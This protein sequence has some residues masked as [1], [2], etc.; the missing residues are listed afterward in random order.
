MPRLPTQP[1]TRPGPSLLQ[2]SRPPPGVLHQS[3]APRQTS[4]PPPSVMSAIAGPRPISLQ[5]RNDQTNVMSVPLRLP[6]QPLPPPPALQQVVPTPVQTNKANNLDVLAHTLKLADL[7]FDFEPAEPV[8]GGGGSSLVPPSETQELKLE[9]LKHLRDSTVPKVVN[10]GDPISQLLDFSN[11]TYQDV[12]SAADTLTVYPG[13][14]AGSTEAEQIIFSSG[15]SSFL[16]SSPVMVQTSRPPNSVMVSSLDASSVLFSV[17]STG[18]PT[19]FS[20]GAGG[21]GDISDL[22][23]MET[24]STSAFPPFS[25]DKKDQDK[26][27]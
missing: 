8:R 1:V 18:S 14:G 13:P 21:P 9:D 11:I 2:T 25:Q 5:S 7:D 16:G 20:S 27:W 10:N 15:S 3:A 24:Q 12:I 6:T 26:W 17:P 22:I 23:N 4:R 19:S